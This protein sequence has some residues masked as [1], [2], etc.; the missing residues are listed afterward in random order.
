[1]C[2]NTAFFRLCQPGSVDH[3]LIFKPGNIQCLPV[4][5]L[6]GIVVEYRTDIPG[7]LTEIIDHPLLDIAVFPAVDHIQERIGLISFIMTDPEEP[8]RC[9]CRNG[10]AVFI[11][12]IDLI[13][14]VSLTQLLQ[15]L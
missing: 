3:I 4:F 15:C 9:T 7:C 10:P 11:I 1:M 12:D 14:A 2:R 8:V 5:I 6:C 13:D